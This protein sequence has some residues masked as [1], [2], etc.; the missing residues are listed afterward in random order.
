[1]KTAIYCRVG[2]KEQANY[3]GIAKRNEDYSEGDMFKKLEG[4]TVITMNEN[5]QVI[6][7]D[8]VDGK[9]VERGLLNGPED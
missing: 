9:I 2:N 1:M 5:K 8:V 3:E 7:A 4:Q 6:E